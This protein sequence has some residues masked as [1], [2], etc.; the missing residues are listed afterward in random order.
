MVR[1]TAGNALGDWTWDFK[2]RRRGFNGVSIRRYESPATATEIVIEVGRK[3][4]LV[5]GRTKDN[6]FLSIMWQ[7]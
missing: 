5:S 3:N 6:I 2:D 1:A 4:G 7:R